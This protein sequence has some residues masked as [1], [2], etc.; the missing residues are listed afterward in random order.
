MTE[1]GKTRQHAKIRY[2]KIDRTDKATEI[3]TSL[4]M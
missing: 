4:L 2:G 1:Q 3:G